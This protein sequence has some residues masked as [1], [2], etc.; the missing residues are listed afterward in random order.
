[1][2]VSSAIPLETLQSVFAENQFFDNKTWR[3]S[4]QPFALEDSLRQEL[5]AIGKACMDFHRAIENLYYKSVEKKSIL[6]NGQ[7]ITPWVADYLERGKPDNIVRWNRMR[8]QSGSLPA[9]IRPDLLLT[10][11][12]FA[13]TE[14]DSVPGGIGLTA[15]LNRLYA[16]N[17][18]DLIGSF[19]AM[20]DG[21]YYSV[22]QA[23]PD[24]EAPLIAI[25]VSEEAATYRPEMEWLAS[26]LQERG[27][28]VFCH[29]P[30]DL[31]P[32]G[33]ALF[34]DG[35]GN[36]EKIDI[37]YRFF[38]LYELDT[39][40]NSDFIMNAWEKG[41]V[42][43][44]PPPKTYQE[45]KLTLA[46]FHHHLLGEYWKDHLPRS[47]R[48]TLSRLIPRSWVIDPT[49]LPPGAILDGPTAQNRPLHQ[50]ED[51]TQA[52]QK[53]RNLIL[54][55]SGFHHDAEG[56]RSVLLGSDCSKEEWTEGLQDAIKNASRNPHI[57]QEYRKPA[58]RQHDLY[59][60][61]GKIAPGEGRVRI[62]PYY[63]THERET[64]KPA[65][66]LCTFCPSDKKIIHGMTDA[67]MLPARRAD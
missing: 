1:M 36:P 41:E 53:E 20:L 27:R 4:P 13:L 67:A 2:P 48:K 64:P 12:G 39:L 32:L 31:I 56:A 40:P 24:R 16:G 26:Q 62:C 23:A 11:D 14:M 44:S 55:I 33:D 54:K 17:N 58:R 9:V 49:P 65:G 43:L 60:G 47:S 57:L 34:R 66:I 29:Y 37:I 51:L 5:G 19:E 45:E 63:F 10:E 30:E 52:S 38:E 28:R 50:W 21:F 42:A 15:Y 25:V 35:E 46:L 22:A 18:D 61:E 6:R 7:L 59:D 8:A 3:L